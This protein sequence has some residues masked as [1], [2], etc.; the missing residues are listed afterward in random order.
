MINI[1]E[2]FERLIQKN[3]LAQQHHFHF[4]TFTATRDIEG[5]LAALRQESSIFAI[6]DLTESKTY[7]SQ[8]GAWFNRRIASAFILM[9]Y[10]PK[11]RSDQAA[12]LGVCRELLRQIHSRLLMEQIETNSLARVDTETLDYRELGAHFLDS[13]TGIHFQMAIDEPIAL[14]YNP[15]EWSD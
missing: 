11:S 12:Q 14:C 7:Q 3:R 10:R 9:R 6:S 1:A 5:V 4:T 15:Q 8:G 13:A 2:L